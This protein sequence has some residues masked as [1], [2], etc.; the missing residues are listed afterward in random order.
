M[1]LPILYRMTDASN[2]W[3]LQRL[4][5][6][7]RASGSGWKWLVDVSNQVGA[8]VL[9]LAVAGLSVFAGF[10]LPHWWLGPIIFAACY[11]LLFGEGA[12]RVWRVAYNATEQASDDPFASFELDSLWQFP[13]EESDERILFLD[14][15]FTNRQPH[16]RVNLD[17]QLMWQMTLAGSPVGSPHGFLRRYDTV[18]KNQLEPPLDIGPEQTVNGPLAFRWLEEPFL[19]FGE[20]PGMTVADRTNIFLRLVD[21]VSGSTRDVP[22]EVAAPDE[23]DAAPSLRPS[24]TVKEKITSEG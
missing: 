18:W 4:R 23:R 6:V 5:F 2:N 20:G 11:A 9:I 15:R 22:V 16:R 10:K 13:D 14:L 17:A 21:H 8:V 19:Q 3:L 12:F 24:G 7:A 1:P